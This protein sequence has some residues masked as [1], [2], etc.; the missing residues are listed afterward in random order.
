VRPV[1]TV[2]EMR[3]ADAAAL[4]TIDESVLIGRAGTAVAGAALRLLGGAYGRRVVVVAGRG[5]NGADGR[6]AALA[7]ERR[8]ARVVVLEASRPDELP[9]C[10]LVLDAAYGTG[11]HGRYEAAPAPAGA[12][13]LAVDIPSGVEGDTGT[14]SGRP[15]AA[16]RT[17]TFA[18]LKPGL[19]Q[20]DGAELS[21]ALEVADIGLA[22]GP[23][24][25]GLVEDD[26][27]AARVPR[28]PRQ[29]HKWASA[30]G[31]V[32]GSPGMEGAAG[33]RRPRP[34]CGG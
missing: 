9:A 18:A 16:V 11:F 7:L 15:L 12:P 20:G 8:G 3:A 24:G 27:V 31:V 21:G 17:V 23:A 22:T 34:R 29:T 25:I 2:D 10:D 5:H 19:L 13:V 6:V 33:T 4:A 26:D 14:A 28:R 32:A 30:V 1:L